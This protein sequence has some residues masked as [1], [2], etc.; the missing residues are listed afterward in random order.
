M[1]KLVRFFVLVGFFW[2]CY[3]NSFELIK[4]L[5]IVRYTEKIH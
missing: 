5:L 4:L 3:R 1:S 2:H